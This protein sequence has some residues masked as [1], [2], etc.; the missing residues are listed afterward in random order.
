MAKN[1][2]AGVLANDDILW[3]SAFAVPP[4]LFLILNGQGGGHGG[5]AQ[6]VRAKES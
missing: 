1:M 3:Y 6:L 2:H 4:A 5:V